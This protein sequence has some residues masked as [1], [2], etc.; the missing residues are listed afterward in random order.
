M[1][2]LGVVVAVQ[3]VMLH[4]EGWRTVPGSV[5]DWFSAAGAVATVM[6][7]I[8]AWLVYRRDSK[9]RSRD[10]KSRDDEDRRRQAELI[11][12][13]LDDHIDVGD[14]HGNYARLHLVNASQG[15]V[16]DVYVH[17]TSEPKDSV[18]VGLAAPEHREA[19]GF[20]HVLPPTT[21]DVTLRLPDVAERV[22]G[23]QIYFRDARS[24]RWVRD[25]LGMLRE[26]E[27]DPREVVREDFWKVKAVG[28]N[29][30]IQI[31]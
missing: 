1:L 30:H 11:T 23:L 4:R 21:C 29:P 22:I 25:W 10:E 5:P 19:W 15:V 20:M 28:P 12:G 14:E 26:T 27:Y 31:L 18:S 8:V 17:V 13:W 9:N 6:A 2:A 3:A 24:Q 16:Y 7:L